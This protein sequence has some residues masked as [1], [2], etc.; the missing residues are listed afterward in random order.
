MRVLVVGAGAVGGYIGGRLLQAGRDVT[1]LVRPG[2]AEQI[3]KDGFA[4][5]VA[6]ERA[7]ELT[8]RA[9]VSEQIEAPYDL[10]LVTCKAYDLESAMDGFAPAVGPETAIL[11]LLN[12]L[13]HLDL[14]SERFG[15]SRLLGGQ[16]VITATLDER[17]HAV[18]L[19]PTATLTF[20]ELN[21][22][23]SRRTEAIA[24]TMQDAGFAV[25]VSNAVLLEMWEKWVL[26]ATF[27]GM[28][29]LMRGAIGDIVAAGAAGL[30]EALLEEC[31]HIAASEDQRIRPEVLQRI[32]T[33]LTQANSTIMASMLRDLERGTKT[34]ADHVLGDLLDRQPELAVNSPSLLRIAY[35]HLKTYEARRA[36]EGAPSAGT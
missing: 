18:L 5:R 22:T 6:A 4:V 3:R 33:L 9:I 28:T 24:T 36:R 30:T 29:C 35:L 7:D 12:G 2:R 21:S 27:A 17:G 11:P 23:L 31:R 14:L 34:E 16:C 15:A 32:R 8:V 26:L 19:G 13:R 10:V 1:F 25:Q 20:G